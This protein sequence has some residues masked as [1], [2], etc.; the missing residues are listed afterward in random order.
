ML[1]K[2]LGIIFTICSDWEV[3]PEFELGFG[4]SLHVGL[5]VAVHSSHGLC[6]WQLDYQVPLT[7]LS[8]HSQRHYILWVQAS[9]LTSLN[10]Y[11]LVRIQ[12]IDINL[13]CLLE[14]LLQFLPDVMDF[15]IF[16]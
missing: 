15:T 2:S 13:L 3:S 5:D 7:C 1:L 4:A 12:L 10:L 14:P 8:A 11:W 9:Y 6:G 16:D